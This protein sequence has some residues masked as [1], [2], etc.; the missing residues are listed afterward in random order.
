MVIGIAANKTQTI[1]ENHIPT[2]LIRGVYF[3]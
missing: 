2:F 1:T 3:L